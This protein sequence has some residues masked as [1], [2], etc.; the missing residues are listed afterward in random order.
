MRDPKL[1]QQ[2]EPRIPDEWRRHYMARSIERLPADV[3]VAFD[4]IHQVQKDKD[5]LRDD[6]STATNDLKFANLKIWILTGVAL[7]QSGLLAWALKTIF[8]RLPK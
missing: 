2:S 1:I 7:A 5:Q 3:T 6:L 8:D 4:R